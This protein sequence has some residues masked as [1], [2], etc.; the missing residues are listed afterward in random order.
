MEQISA[1]GIAISYPVRW[2]ALLEAIR[3]SRGMAVAV[4]EEQVTAAH[5]TLARSGLF[6]EPTSA[7]VAAALA[8]LPKGTFKP[9]EVV[10][11]V[12]TGH[13]LKHPPLIM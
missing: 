2:A 11:G 7:T 6:V 3:Y 9:R 5:H 4:T 13:G 1:D 10:V 8:L 12:L